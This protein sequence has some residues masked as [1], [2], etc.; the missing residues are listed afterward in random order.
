VTY[1]AKHKT[2]DESCTI[3]LTNKLLEKKPE[4][5]I[6]ERKVEILDGAN[7]DRVGVTKFQ[8]NA[9]IL[10]QDHPATHPKAQVR[11]T[12]SE[13]VRIGNKVY[14]CT[15]L[16]IQ[17]SDAIREFG[18]ETEEQLEFKIWRCPEVPGC[19]VKADIKA[20]AEN[21]AFELSGRLVEFSIGD[22]EIK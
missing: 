11:E 6:V 2:S 15:I 3:R 7:K 1:V 5:V 4:Y 22:K 21:H 14:P 19:I 9:K 10:P 20:T 16:H 18:L 13:D 17:V 8:R 12:D